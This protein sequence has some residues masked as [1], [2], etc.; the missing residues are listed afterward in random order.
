MWRRGSVKWKYLIMA[1]K[2]R[3][4]LVCSGI[5]MTITFDPTTGLFLFSQ[6]IIIVVI[7]FK[8]WL[9]CVWLIW[10]EK[11]RNTFLSRD[12][13]HTVV[14]MSMSKCKLYNLTACSKVNRSKEK[15]NHITLRYMQ[16]PQNIMI[17]TFRTGPFSLKR[18]DRQLERKYSSEL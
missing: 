4:S 3:N 2:R 6:A 14:C 5:V 8:M 9:S 12:D 13:V 1:K 16:S 18:N 10:Y 7:I 17:T 11:N 15:E